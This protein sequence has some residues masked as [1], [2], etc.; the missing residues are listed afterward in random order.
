MIPEPLFLWAGRKDVPLMARS[1]G[2]LTGRAVGFL[3][4]A[5]TAAMNYVQESKLTGVRPHLV[6]P[7]PP[8]L[9]PHLRSAPQSIPVR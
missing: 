9:P 1:A 5:R 8:S 7:P 4:K 6:A 3:V 2:V